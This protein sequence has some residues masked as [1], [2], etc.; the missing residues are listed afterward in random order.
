MLLAAL[1]Q[2]TTRHYGFF[3]IE[4][5]GGIIVGLIVLIVLGLLLWRIME[6]VVKKVVSDTDWQQVIK[7]LVMVL[8]VLLFL[9]LFGLY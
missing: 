8:L 5:L 1:L 7:L 9:H 6:I 3:G 4:G 2:Y